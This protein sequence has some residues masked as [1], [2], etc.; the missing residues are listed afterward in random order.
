M[1]AKLLRHYIR[2]VVSETHMARVPDQLVSDDGTGQKRDQGD[3]ESGEE[4]DE[5][6]GVGAVVGYTGPLGADPDTLG[7]KKN[8]SQ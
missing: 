4:M 7:R 8:R 2:L 6:C 5:F 3:E 1:D